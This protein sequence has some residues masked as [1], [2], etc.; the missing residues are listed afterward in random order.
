MPRWAIVKAA[1]EA[2]AFRY[3]IYKELEGTE[4]QALA[5]MLR[6]MDTVG[7]ALTEAGRGRQR[8]QVFRVSDRSYV[9]RVTSRWSPDYEAHFT[10]AELIAD[11]HD[12]ELPSSTSGSKQGP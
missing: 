8:R 10:L 2:E 3:N 6:I 11:T 1:G 7:E 5:E 12:D 4:A 9:V